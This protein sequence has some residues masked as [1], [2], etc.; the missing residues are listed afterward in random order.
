MRSTTLDELVVEQDGDLPRVRD[1]VCHCAAQLELRSLVQTRLITAASELSRNMLVHA[2]GGSVHIRRLD[3]GDRSGLRVEFVDR[4]PGIDDVERAMQSGFSTGT[5]LGLGLGGA[6]RL[7]EEFAIESSCR[8]TR[9][10]I[11][12]WRSRPP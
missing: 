6:R 1:A 12:C 3:D 11:T 7:V 2:G 10:S 5:G 9:I 4:G 8:G